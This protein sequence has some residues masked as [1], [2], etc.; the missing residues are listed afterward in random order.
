MRLKVNEQTLVVSLLF[1]IH[2]VCEVPEHLHRLT[3][4]TDDTQLLH[5]APNEKQRDY[6]TGDYY[7]SHFLE[8]NIVRVEQLFEITIYFIAKYHY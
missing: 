3:L 5:Y 2:S 4:N 7:Q 6:E 1:L 8:K